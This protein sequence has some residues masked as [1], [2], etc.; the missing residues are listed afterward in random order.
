M[1]RTFWLP[2]AGM[3][4]PRWMVAALLLQLLALGAILMWVGN[5]GTA[6]GLA[7]AAAGASSFWLW[8]APAGSLLL[9]LHQGHE[10]RL[11]RHSA[12][13]FARALLL[14][15]VN[16]LPASALIGW[17]AADGD[18]AVFMSL[19]LLC[20]L[21]GQLLF[22]V[23]PFRLLMG[24]AVVPLLLVALAQLLP[25][26]LSRIEWSNG[27][28]IAAALLVAGGAGSLLLGL[29]RRFIR[30]PAPC[31]GADACVLDFAVGSGAASS[32]DEPERGLRALPQFLLPRQRVRPGDSV[33]QR[34]AQLLGP[35]YA[36]GSTRRMLVIL[37]AIG[38]LVFL[39]AAA[40][41]PG[42]H[43]E[44]FVAQTWLAVC[45]TFTVSTRLGTLFRK[46]APELSELALLP[47]QGNTQQRGQRVMRLLLRRPLSAQ[48]ALTMAVM[49][50]L[51][52][53]GL[54]HSWTQAGPLLGLSLLAVALMTLETARYIEH[55]QGWFGKPWVGSAVYA[56][57]LTPSLVVLAWSQIGQA[58]WPTTVADAQAAAGVAL[59]ALLAFSAWRARAAQRRSIQRPHALA[60]ASDRIAPGQHA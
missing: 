6:I 38:L 44:L 57:A 20:I 12:G 9:H 15:V 50:S 26:Q 19:L 10:L 40:T 55:G 33:E 39:I 56:A 42:V 18:W 3:L 36:P 47:G 14:L 53:I 32:F 46:H 5:A 51:W 28:R 27:M 30:R 54:A 4:R 22:L 1:K 23:T 17:R 21:L 43:L 49:T 31:V 48:L 60:G 25:W 52:V 24:A 16:L 45:V 35:P 13:Y 11:P 37:G 29:G 59:I 8:A 2:Y 7:L 34:V 58:L 41:K